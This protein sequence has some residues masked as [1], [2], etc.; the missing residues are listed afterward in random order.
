MAAGSLAVLVSAVLFVTARGTG[1]AWQDSD[2][3]TGARS[4]PDP[5]GQHAE[6]PL[7]RHKHRAHDASAAR[8]SR[9]ELV[10][11]EGQEARLN[12]GQGTHTYSLRV[13]VSGDFEIALGGRPALFSVDRHGGVHVGASRVTA[14]SVSAARFS[15]RD[16]AQWSLAALEIFSPRESTG[17]STPLQTTCGSVTMLGGYPSPAAISEARNGISEADSPPLLN[18]TKRFDGLPKHTA[19]R[20]VAT[21]HFLDDWQGETAYLTLDGHFAWTQAHSERGSVAAINVCGRNRY[22]ESRF[23]QG[24]DVTVPHNAA[25]V[26]VAFGSSLAT[27]QAMFGVSSVAVYIR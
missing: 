22:P 4:V 11:G 18:Y 13:G 7:P 8:S 23:S 10:A 25:E 17:W 6:M 1:R 9:L 26:A 21:V 19:L 14:L 20:V 15:V 16:V 12:M 5:A 24:I 3:A 2:K 27:D